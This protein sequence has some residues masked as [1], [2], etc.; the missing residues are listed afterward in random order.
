MDLPL[1]LLDSYFTCRRWTL[2]WAKCLIWRFKKKIPQTSTPNF[3][4]I[5]FPLTLFRL[6]FHKSSVVILGSRTDSL[7]FS[8]GLSLSCTVVTVLSISCD[9]CTTASIGWGEAEG[10]CK[11]ERSAPGL[12]PLTLWWSSWNVAPVSLWRSP[13]HRVSVGAAPSAVCF[14][15]QSFALTSLP[16]PLLLVA[17][18]G[19]WCVFCW[20]LS[21]ELL[22]T[23]E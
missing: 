9:P 20:G 4:P 3:V 15:T 22:C 12:W 2:Q 7:Y 16:P 6:F 23:T 5:F 8:W 13:C 14:G 11:Q 17:L 19:T 21:P 10:Q 18:F 1:W